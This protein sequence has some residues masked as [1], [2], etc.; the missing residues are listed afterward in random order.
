VNRPDIPVPSDRALRALKWSIVVTV[1]AAIIG[2]IVA[3]S[4]ISSRLDAA[5]RERDNLAEYNAAQDST[6]AAQQ[7]ALDQANKRLEE[8]GKAP[9]PVPE[10]PEVVVGPSGATGAQGPVGPRG[11]AGASIVGPVG[12]RG[13]AGDDG[14][15]VVG[16]QGPAGDDGESVAGPKGDTG[17]A[18]RDGKDAT[19][20]MVDA[21]VS[22]YCSVRGECVG[23]QGPPGADST[24]PGPQGPVGPVGPQGIPGVVNVN[25]SPACADLLPNM[26]ISLTYDAGTQTITLVCA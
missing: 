7:S 25:T 1:A 21:A 23:P 20:E 5:D 13:P 24:V 2:C 26:S 11:P 19:P 15:T 6:I 9:V 22:R 12:P 10:A 4:S 3:F 14:R 8:A 17:E 18:G 16:P